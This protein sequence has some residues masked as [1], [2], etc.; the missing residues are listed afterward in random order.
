MDSHLGSDH[1]AARIGL[2][3]R[4]ETARRAH[5]D[6]RQRQSQYSPSSQTPHFPEPLVPDPTLPRREPPIGARAEKA[7]PDLRAWWAISRVYSAAPRW[8]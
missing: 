3:K 4:S 5:G 7:L 2:A 6:E 8:A 1:D